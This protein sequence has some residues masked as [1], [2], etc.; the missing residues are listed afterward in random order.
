[1]TSVNAMK[2]GAFDY[3]V[4]PVSAERLSAVVARAMQ[5][6]AQRVAERHELQGLC[7]R[8]ARLTR[9][10]HTI[11]VGVASHRLNKQMAGDLGTCER[12]VKALRAR[13]MAKLN[14][15]TVPEVVRAAAMLERAGVSL[16]ADVTVEADESLPGAWRSPFLQALP[17]SN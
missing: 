10:E 13:M 5:L 4:K 8:F 15:T 1:M 3:L 16:T 7:S 14:V 6:D 9:S 2:M 11:F 17:A 12:T